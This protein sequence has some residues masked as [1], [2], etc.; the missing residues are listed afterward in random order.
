MSSR[1]LR[2]KY[3]KRRADAR[4]RR[5]TVT[6]GAEIRPPIRVVR[7]LAAFDALKSIRITRARN[8]RR[9]RYQHART[10]NS[11]VSTD[12]S[13]SYTTESIREVESGKTLRKNTTIN[14]NKYSEW[15][16]KVTIRMCIRFYFFF[17][18]IF[19]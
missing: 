6:F 2:A 11:D 4:C 16:Q 17:T 7:P 9:I 19:L 10:W 8:A 14:Q 15:L 1:R 18:K 12:F 3:D 5:P 13:V